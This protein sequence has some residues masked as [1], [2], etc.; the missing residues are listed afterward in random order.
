M[1]YLTKRCIFLFLALVLVGC[2]SAPRKPDIIARGDYSYTREYITWLVQREMKKYNVT[3]LSIALVDD[4]RVIWAE[5]FGFADKTGQV[6]A[7]AETVYRVASLSKLFTATAAMQLAEQ[8]KL[9]ID[10]PLKKYLP[11]FSI[12]SRFPDSSPITLRT[13]MT[14]HS[15]LPADLQKGMWT[16]KPEPFMKVVHRVR[17]EYAPFPPNFLYSYSNLAVT[18]LGCVLERISGRPFASLLEK[19]LLQ[20]LGMSQA[21]FSTGPD[22]SPLAAKAYSGDREVPD[23]SVRDLPAAGLNATVLDLSRFMEM[24]FAGGMA[25]ERR[26][27]GRET[28]AEMLRPQNAAVPLDHDF[29]TGLGWV[30]SGMSHLAIKNAGPVAHHSGM[31][32]YHRSFLIIL[33]DHK[34]GVAVLANSATA[35]GVVSRVAAAALKLALEAKTGIKQPGRRDPPPSAGALSPGALEGY[36]GL[37][38]TMAG[39]VPVTVKGDQLRAAIMGR[40]LRLTPRADGLLKVGYK[41]LGLFP[42][43]LGDFDFIGLGRA[44]LA[45]RDILKMRLDEQEVLIGERLKPLPIPH[46]WLERLGEYECVNA[47]DDTVLFK[48]LRLRQDRGFLI[49]DYEMPHFVK[50]TISLALQPLSE[51][52]AIICGLSRGMGETICAVRTDGQEQLQYSGYLL[53]KK[54]STP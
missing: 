1:R 14:H 49:V 37:Y 15:G 29:R 19:S 6:P 54:V 44:T 36:A 22:P 47:G 16:K 43:S 11:E 21:S 40:E 25:H 48:R 18:L 42:I 8:G 52:E 34:L 53:R 20:P 28:L 2:S 30:L 27:I 9:D 33:P 35:Q 38:A 23:V 5:G 39:V 4:Q 26:V 46:K 10:Q 32:L 12:K 51:T 31:T 13:L 41:L 24:V 7:T 45:G 17:E 3:G 50:G